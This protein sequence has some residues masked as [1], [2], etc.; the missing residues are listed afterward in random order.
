MLVPVLAALFVGTVLWVG[1]RPRTDVVPTPTPTPPTTAVRWP[2]YRIQYD[3]RPRSFPL[4][5]GSV[6]VTSET[7]DR[8]FGVV[9]AMQLVSE[10][11]GREAVV[12][13]DGGESDRSPPSPPKGTL[14]YA[15]L[16]PR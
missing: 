11:P 4:P 14:V 13:W 10:A 12:R 3:R 7:P 5:A 1:R 15:T 8:A 16:D 6:W 9:A 2:N